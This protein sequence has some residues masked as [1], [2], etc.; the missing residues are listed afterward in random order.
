MRK[1][2]GYTLIEMMVAL[3]IAMFI[4]ITTLY[5][6]SGQVRT[7]FHTARKQQTTEE[8]QAAFEAVTDLLRQAEMCLTCNPAQQISITY[9]AG[10][11]NP[12]GT[13]T[14]YLANDSIDLDFTVPAGYAIWPNNTAPYSENAMHL[15]WSQA[16]GALLLSSGTDA[17]AAQGASAVAIAGSTGRLNTRIVNF[18]VWPLTVGA[19]N[20]PAT[21]T[22]ASD[23][24]T[25]GYHVVMTAR[26]G[27]PD[28]TY[29]N[30]LDPNGAMRNYRTVTYEADILPRNW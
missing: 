6:Y 20:V 17:A 8:I 28:G 30:K 24:P 12:N 1:L 2:G 14:P 4:S 7:F 11:A 18:D 19:S 27:S 16:N 22:A 23:K 29:T 3:T 25:A 5:L 21:G 13:Q 10:I 15:T 9:P 26:V